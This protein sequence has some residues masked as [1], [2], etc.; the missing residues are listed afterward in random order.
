MKAP[1]KPPV[2][3]PGLD[4]H[5]KRMAAMTPKEKEEFAAG[6]RKKLKEERKDAEDQRWKRGKYAP[7]L[8][9]VGKC[10][11]C[12]TK[13]IIEKWKVSYDGELIMGGSSNARM[14]MQGY[15]C[16]KCGIRYEFVP[17]DKK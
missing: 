11:V 5:L 7:E 15:Y 10:V 6:I 4:E 1:E 17:K 13:T 16:T 12:K 2:L 14:G 3:V 9:P 8:H